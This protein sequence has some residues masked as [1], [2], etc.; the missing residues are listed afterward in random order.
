MK[1]YKIEIKAASCK[2]NASSVTDTLI[3]ALNKINPAVPLMERTEKILP[4]I[5]EAVNENMN[6]DEIYLIVEKMISAELKKDEIYIS[7]K[8]KH[9]NA[10]AQNILS[11]AVEELMDIFSVKYGQPA[12]FKCFLGIYNPFPRSVLTKE[13]FL[14]YDISDKVFLSAS[15]HEINHMIFFDKWK[16][17]HGYETLKEP[18]FPDILWFL[19]E[20]IIEPTLNDSRIQNIVPIKQNAYDSFKKTLIDGIPLTYYI[21]NL[22]DS[23]KNIDDFIDTAYCFLRENKVGECFN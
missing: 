16:N 5:R 1:N 8:I 20:L 14:H 12:E 19:E 3:T 6:Y 23:C 21:Q 17:M 13:Y 9:F 10:L 18:D 7:E 22:Y 4:G 2:V 15:L 11:E